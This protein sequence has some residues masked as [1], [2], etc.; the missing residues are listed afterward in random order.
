MTIKRPSL[1]AEVRKILGRKVKRLRKD[2]YL[3]ASVY[4]KGFESV[5]IK[6]LQTDVEKLFSDIGTAGLFDLK[7]GDENIP[8]LFKNPQYHPVSDILIHIDLHKVDLSQKIVA[9]IPVVLIGESEA[10]K[11][12]AVLVPISDSIEVEALPA[13]LP[14]KMEIDISGLKE[15]GDVLTVSDLPTTD[16][17]V[18]IKTSKD[19]AIVKVEEAKKE[20]IEAVEE[21]VKGEP[22]ETEGEEGEKKEG[23]EEVEEEKEEKKD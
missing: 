9:E 14:E 2:G 5:S 11:L 7:L 1:K 19:Q 10:V 16:S 4:G 3:P 15:I 13:D 8:V 23:E 22:T 12:G 20:V 6:F 17:K 21:A 18:E